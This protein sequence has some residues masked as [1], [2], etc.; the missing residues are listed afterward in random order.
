MVYSLVDL[1]ALDAN[2][3]Y[4]MAAGINNVGTVAGISLNN[5][6]QQVFIYDYTIIYRRIT[7]DLVQNG[8]KACC[9]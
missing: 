6:A 1:G 4:S 5:F 3:D 2:S 7:I 8:V 9:L